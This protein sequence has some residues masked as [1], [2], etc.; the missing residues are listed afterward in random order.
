MR[1]EEKMKY[2]NRTKITS[3]RFFPQDWEALT[4]AAVLARKNTG[5]PVT[6]SDLIRRGVG[7]MVEGEYGIFWLDSEESV[8][9]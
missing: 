9:F 5:E 3:I 6:V 7:R 1:G 4:A 8:K 2:D